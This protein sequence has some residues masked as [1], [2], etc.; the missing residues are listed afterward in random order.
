[1]VVPIPATLL[2]IGFIANIMISLAVLMVALN[3]AKPLD[4]SVLPDRAAVRDPAAPGAERRLDPRRAGQR[5]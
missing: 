5:P 2:D 3:V 4:F 1:M